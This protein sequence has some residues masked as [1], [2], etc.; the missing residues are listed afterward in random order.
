MTYRKLGLGL[1]IA[2]IG[3]MAFAVSAQAKIKFLID[4]K[5]VPA[6]LDAG[7]SGE[8]V[9]AGSLLVQALNLRLECK[10]FSVNKGL[11]TSGTHAEGELLYEECA[12]FTLAGEPISTC[13][14]GNGLHVKAEALLLPAE[15]LE[16]YGLKPALLAEKVK[17]PIPFEGEECTLPESNT[18]KGELCLEIDNNDTANPEV[19][20]SDTIQEKCKPRTALEGLL[21]ELP[22]STGSNF[23]DKLLYGAQTANVDGAAK[24][25]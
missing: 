16:A 20:L 1:V 18:V 25:E 11:L 4:Q 5:A 9:G 6:N 3:M 2:A 10:K 22:T 24:H 8:Q 13:H 15:F 21:D 23:K 7:V 17:A 12:P 14:V 19:L